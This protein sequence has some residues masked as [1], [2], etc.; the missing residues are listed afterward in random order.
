MD[1]TDNDAKL[2][3]FSVDTGM[4]RKVVQERMTMSCEIDR[5]MYVCV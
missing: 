3:G 5:Y 1:K 4:E 2:R